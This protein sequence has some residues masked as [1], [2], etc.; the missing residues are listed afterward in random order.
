MRIH[1]FDWSTEAYRPQDRFEAWK[2]ALNETHLGFDLDGAGANAIS[3][4]V[5]RDGL[6]DLSFVSCSSTPCSGERGRRQIE[7]TSDDCFGLLYIRRGREQVTDHVGQHLL[8]GGDLMFWDSRKTQSFKVIEPLEK[9][10]LMIPHA[11]MKAALP[12]AEDYAGTVLSGPLTQLLRNSIEALADV[13]GALGDREAIAAGELAILGLSNALRAG[14][15]WAESSMRPASLESALRY[16]DLHLDDEE[17]GPKA[18]ARATDIS[19][20]YLHLLFEHQGTTVSRWIKQRRLVRCHAD[21]S[22]DRRTTIT[23][24]AHRWGFGDAAQLT[25][26]FRSA[27][28]CTPR[29]LRR[30]A[31]SQ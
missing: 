30:S 20:R 1:P 6:G 4:R 11:L 19:V 14:D 27:Y 3:A 8:T 9:L 22:G 12:N 23:R 24:I 5:H 28:G 29:D 18:I 17:L 31:R 15:G 2:V 16:I 21:I 13:S 25:R 7:N 10:T 26:A